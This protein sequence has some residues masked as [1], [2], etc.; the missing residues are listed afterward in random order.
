[1]K[2]S[3]SEL[4]NVVKE[5]LV[6]I[7]SEGLTT[8]AVSVNETRQM[9]EGVSR[10]SQSIIPA[11]TH[12]TNKMSFLPNEGIRSSEN[13]NRSHLI[14]AAK[15]LTND[16]MIA[17][18]L[19]DTAANMTNDNLNES[20]SATRGPSISAAGDKAARIM[21]ESD[22]LDIFD[23]SASKWSALAFAE[24]KVGV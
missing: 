11:R 24:K 3:R 12:P 5:C 22:P 21:F 14:S 10:S 15:T 1:M 8:S 19:A 16:S 9:R 13:N 20:T 17:E 4:K 7:L 2:L 6:E 18:M 23:E